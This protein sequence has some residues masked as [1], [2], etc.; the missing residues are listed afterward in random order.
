MPGCYAVFHKQL[1]DLTLLEPALHRLHRHH[2]SPVRLFTR[3]GHAPLVELIEGVEFVRPPALVRLEDLYCFDPLSKSAF[4]AWTTPAAR[5][6]LII[7]E[8]RELRW[9]HPLLFQRP[10]TPELGNTYVAEFFW[11]HTPV[12]DSQPF[13]MPRLLN[14]PADWAPNGLASRSFVL[15]NATSGWPMKSWTTTGWSELIQHFPGDF[16]LTHGPQ[17]WQR[18]RCEEIV[19]HSGGKARIVATGLREFLWLCANARA[20]LTVD[21]AASHLAA[22]FGVPALTLFGPTNIGQW[23]RPGPSH[24]AVRA[25]VDKDGV[26]RLRRLASDPVIAAA[27][28]ILRGGSDFSVR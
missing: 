13:R 5:R 7:P 21:G 4:R 15:I 24:V 18:T 6:H 23:H 17:D 16:I 8:R 25:P 19:S 1:G 12:P 22:A 20:V 2:G 27:E 9:F 26:R 28:P 3:N 10:E 14:P 11:N